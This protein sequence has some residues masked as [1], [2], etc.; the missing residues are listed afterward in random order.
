M[1][2]IKFRAWDTQDK[3]M[4]FGFP[5]LENNHFYEIKGSKYPRRGTDFLVLEIMQYTGL[6]DKNGKEIYEGDIIVVRT[7]QDSNAF[8]GVWNNAEQKPIPQVIEFDDK[9]YGAIM[10]SDS[11]YNPG[12]WEV[13]GNIYENKELLQGG[14]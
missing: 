11:G 4:L 14:E 10:P 3:Q 9:P 8:D 7:L 13:I 1:R 5:N 6:K 12:Y 2:E